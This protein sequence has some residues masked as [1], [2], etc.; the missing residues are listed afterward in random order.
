MSVRSQH[1]KN[2]I[3]FSLRGNSTVEAIRLK[4]QNAHESDLVDHYG[5]RLNPEIID[6]LPAQLGIYFDGLSNNNCQFNSRIQAVKESSVLLPLY[7]SL[8]L[9]NL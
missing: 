3:I 6:C 5:I 8:C 4:Y 9:C 7:S 2:I 1:S